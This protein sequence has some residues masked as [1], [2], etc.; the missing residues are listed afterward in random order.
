MYLTPG[1]EWTLVQLG[2]EETRGRCG[3]GLEQFGLWRNSGEV[4][5]GS[6]WGLKCCKLMS[7]VEDSA[8]CEVETLWGLR[9]MMKVRLGEGWGRRD[10]LGYLTWGICLLRS[11]VTSLGR[12][13]SSLWFCQFFCSLMVVEGWLTLNATMKLVV[14]RVDC[15]ILRLVQV[16]GWAGLIKYYIAT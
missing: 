9:R 7:I 13:F 11:F 8:W 16:G 4:W 3:W 14:D 5:L 10:L 2:L 1:G 6:G 15:S 12:L